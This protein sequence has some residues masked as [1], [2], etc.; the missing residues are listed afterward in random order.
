MDDEIE[1]ITNTAFKSEGG[2]FVLSWETSEGRQWEVM[3]YRDAQQDSNGDWV[4]TTLH[5]GR[6]DSE[7]AEHPPGSTF[8][9]LDTAIRM[10]TAQT[11]WIDTDLTH[12]AI[13][14]GMTPESAAVETELYT[15]RSQ[16]EWPVAHLFLEQDSAGD[17]TAT[18]VP[19]HRFGTSLNPIASNNWRGYRWTVTDGSNTITREGTSEL[20]VF[21]T[22]GWGAVTVTVSQLNRL[23]GAGPSV[24]EVIP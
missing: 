18:V 24:S 15:A 19:R 11:A 9:L 14:N 4:L 10:V 8:V 21:D 7:T 1:S 6:L 17:T 5:R 23:T 13:T 2:A 12:R 3:Q 16:T 20:E 22:S